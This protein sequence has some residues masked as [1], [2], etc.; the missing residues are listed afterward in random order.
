ME[1]GPVSAGYRPAR[2]CS[3]MN[4][5]F[6]RAR[7][8]KAYRHLA[9]RDRGPTRSSGEHRRKR[10]A[11]ARYSYSLGQETCS[12][13]PQGSRRGDR[14]HRI[15]EGRARSR[16]SFRKRSRPGALLDAQRAASRATGDGAPE[17]GGA[18]TRSGGNA[19]RGLPEPHRGDRVVVKTIRSPYQ[20]ARRDAGR[21]EARS[22]RVKC[23]WLAE[24]GRTYPRY[25]AR[26]CGVPD[27]QGDGPTPL[28][29]ED[30]PVGDPDA[31]VRRRGS[32]GNGGVRG[33]CDIDTT[34]GVLA[35]RARSL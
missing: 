29:R 4:R 8:Q 24:V 10:T 7:P 5:L 17:G 20:A 32:R 14:C 22:R 3:C 26:K 21:T 9:G 1:R 12:G 11:T 30:G 13:P 2:R 31:R 19:G 33:P 15:V 6:R 18:V 28:T 35:R 16:V 27:S 34:K 25:V 23:V